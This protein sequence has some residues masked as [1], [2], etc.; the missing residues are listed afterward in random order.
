MNNNDH[1]VRV[2]KALI[3]NAFISLMK[4]N[5]IQNIT[6][7]ALCAKANI[8]RGTFYT[9]YSSVY[10][11]LSEIENELIKD[12]TVL[13]EP[14]A[15]VNE[16]N[17][18][19]IEFSLPIFEYLASNYEICSLMLGENGDKK[20]LEDLIELGKEAFLNSYLN[21]YGKENIHTISYFYYFISAGCIQIFKQWLT[22]GMV[23]PAKKLALLAQNFV[24]E[25]SKTLSLNKKS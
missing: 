15:K 12:M 20:F 21:L 14:L 8:N 22:N 17:K 18:F 25:G 23:M 7:K 2:T 9:H 5:N 11:L 24:A 6:I 4:E 13:F 10:D 1:R 16:E 3:K 19:S